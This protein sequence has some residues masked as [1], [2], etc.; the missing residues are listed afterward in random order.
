MND[1]KTTGDDNN[2]ASEF[3][4][5]QQPFS[6]TDPFCIG[7][8]EFDQ[9]MRCQICCDFFRAPVSVPNCHHTFCSECLSNHIRAGLTSSK[10]FASCPI[11]RQR[12]EP[13]S[14]NIPNRNVEEMIQKFGCIRNKLLENLRKF[15]EQQSN[16]GNNAVRNENISDQ[17]DSS[18]APESNTE[19]LK[20]SEQ[21]SK[22]RRLPKGIYH[23]LKKK[24]L[25]EKCR[26]IGLNANGNDDLLKARH[27]EYI[28]LHNAQC[29]SFYPLP[30][31]ALIDEVHERERTKRKIANSERLSE[32]GVEKAHWNKLVRSRKEVGMT[33]VTS[34]NSGFD[35]KM[36]AGFSR[37]IAQ[38]RAKQKA[39]KEPQKGVIMAGVCS[40]PEVSKV[41]ED[42][43][44]I[45]KE[46]KN[47]S[48][49]KKD[50]FSNNNNVLEGKNTYETDKLSMTHSLPQEFNMLPEIS[51][52][53]PLC[54]DGEMNENS[55]D[56][57]VVVVSVQQAPTMN[58]ADEVDNIVLRSSPAALI[59][60]KITRKRTSR[61]QSPSSMNQQR[62]SKRSK[63]GTIGPWN[64]TQCTFANTKRTWSR[65]RCEM[66]DVIRVK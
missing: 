47:S 37:I 16:H 56:S 38:Q 24:Q 58:R 54:I 55:N 13:N 21:P 28:R 12:I 52:R 36:K 20:E 66:C 33:A 42:D 59:R 44:A 57:S 61:N 64:C 40:S 7:L 49:T 65:A 39:I 34:G 41:S 63:R 1:F 23:G 22:I 35:A 29:D 27:Q 62:V 31:S 26:K 43:D 51:I 3:V 50:D 17:S 6:R 53:E 9:S 46:M 32:A 45:L 14:K 4:W 8:E 5:T 11:C 2:D 18:T 10:R 30:K 60:R 15:K 25:Q 19:K 48:R